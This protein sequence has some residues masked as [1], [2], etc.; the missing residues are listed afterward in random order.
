MVTFMYKFQDSTILPNL[1]NQYIG[2]SATH[3]VLG[4]KLG[5]IF[6][7][8][9]L[10]LLQNQNE[11]NDL[12][13]LDNEVI[14]KI[15]RILDVSNITSCQNQTIPPLPS[16]GNPKTDLALTIN[17][18]ID[19]RLSIKASKADN[20][21]VAEFSVTDI[22]AG[23]NQQT[24][25][26]LVE[27][28]TK[29]QTEQSAKFFT[30]EQKEELIQILDPIKDSFVRWVITGSNSPTTNIQT[31]T[32]MASFK[33]NY[34]QGCVSI[35]DIEIISFNME[36]VSDYITT[37]LQKRCGFNTGLSWTYATGSAGRKIQFKAKVL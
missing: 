8:Y 13:S 27:L 36:S 29:F 28:L 35:N 33:L 23:I 26:R 4:D 20:V 15:K 30:P 11:N 22:I 6:E 31:P 24:N 21:S 25:T 18:S 10:L 2:V 14:S 19:L 1:F 17:G 12:G 5:D 32:H 34:P 7:E 37:L 3:G 16:G 9:I